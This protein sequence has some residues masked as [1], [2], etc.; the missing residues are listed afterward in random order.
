M[1][2]GEGISLEHKSYIGDCPQKSRMNGHYTL[3]YH[4]SNAVEY[5]IRKATKGP[6]GNE[7]ELGTIVS[8]LH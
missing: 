5:Y 3:Y 6:G 2:W 4:I 7:T 1:G 8:G